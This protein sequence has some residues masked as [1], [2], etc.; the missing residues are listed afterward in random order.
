MKWLIR[1]GMAFMCL[2]VVPLIGVQIA[3]VAVP[4][5]NYRPE[6]ADLAG[7]TFAA[8]ELRNPERF[9]AMMHHL[10]GLNIPIQRRA[11]GDEV[12][13]LRGGA[14]IGDQPDNLRVSRDQQPR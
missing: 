6:T 12:D 7:L 2:F 10:F 9:D 1:L 8:Q 14:F 3:V 13:R 11:R 4:F 5:L